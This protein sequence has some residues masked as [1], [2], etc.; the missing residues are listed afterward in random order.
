[1]PQA[2]LTFQY[3]GLL[4]RLPAKF[5]RIFA[6]QSILDEITATLNRNYI[7]VKP[8]A[9]LWKDEES[10]YRKEANAKDLEAGRQFL[11]KLR[12]FLQAH[13]VIV[14]VE[15]A[16]EVG[17]QRYDDLKN[18][19]GESSTA[20]CLVARGR[21]L[22]L[23]ADDLGLRSL[24]KNE[25]AVRSAWTQSILRAFHQS[26]LIN[27]EE[28]F[29]AILKLALANYTFISIDTDFVMWV[30]RRNKMSIT[31]EVER[32][33]HLLAGPDC[34]EDSAVILLSNLTRQIWLDGVL[35]QQRFL[36]LDA[37]LQALAT[38][39][40]TRQVLERFRQALRVQFRLIPFDLQRILQS[41]DIWER[42]RLR[43]LG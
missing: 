22:P 13:A 38:G 28:Y 40:P 11:E 27:Q 23:Y 5:K 4:D 37:A 21:N 17:K 6:P 1:M 3:V 7:G 29:E 15:E 35:F 32:I 19:I 20:A 42:Q 36:I 25:W 2:E 43:R 41:I 26:G 24:A 31:P 14:P 33:L 8:S 18:L 10:Y 9:A 30:L 39:R 16:L 12:S 34:T